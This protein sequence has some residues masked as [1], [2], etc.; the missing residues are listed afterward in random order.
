ML[1]GKKRDGQ[2]GHV[3]PV[4]AATLHS[5]TFGIQALTRSTGSR[6]LLERNLSPGDLPRPEDN[7]PPSAD[8]ADR[9]P[10]LKR[11][12]GDQRPGPMELL[13]TA[14]RTAGR[15]YLLTSCAGAW[16]GTRNP[17][18]TRRRIWGPRT[19]TWPSAHPF[20]RGTARR[21]ALPAA[22]AAPLA[23]GHPPETLALLE[24]LL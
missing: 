15:R 18:A 5:G 23:G 14:A 7:S 21:R 9:A 4:R 16:K 12:G 13:P 8:P 17:R 20:G 10:G 2:A 22:R 19:P 6:L 1:L 11:S 3:P 24:P